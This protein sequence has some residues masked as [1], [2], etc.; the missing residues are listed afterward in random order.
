MKFIKTLVFFTAII[1]LTSCAS[2]YKPT[3]PKT[4]NYASSSK[5]NNVKLEYKYNLLQKKYAKKE[6]KKGVK[7]VAIKVT[8]NSDNDLMFGSDIK[9]TFENGKQV[10]IVENNYVFKTL[11]QSTPIYLLY[12]LLSPINLY[13]DNGNGSTNNFPIGLIIGPGI[14]AGN[15]ITAASANKKFK[16]E[17]LEFDINGVLIKKGETKYGLIGIQTDTYDSLKLKID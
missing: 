11:K 15:M 1:T 5:V 3:T 10:P 13:T 14:T 9:L 16:T 6:V 8:N 2:S 12:L 7:V 17:L 4:Q